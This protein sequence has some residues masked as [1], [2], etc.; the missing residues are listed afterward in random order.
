MDSQDNLDNAAPP[1]AGMLWYDNSKGGL[2]E[3][4]LAAI[5]YFIN[6]YGYNPSVVY[7]HPTMLE[8]CKPS[9]EGV[10]IETRRWMS[11]NCFLIE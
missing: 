1:R 9:I 11:P 10:A 4:I 3:K 7:I 6:K 2:N 5:K 8:E